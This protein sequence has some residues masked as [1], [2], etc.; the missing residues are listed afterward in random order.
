MSSSLNNIPQTAHPSLRDNGWSLKIIKSMTSRRQ[1]MSS[2]DYGWYHHA[3]IDKGTTSIRMPFS[4]HAFSSRVHE[5]T[6]DCQRLL[7]QTSSVFPQT[8]AVGHLSIN[9][10]RGYILRG[11]SFTYLCYSAIVSLYDSGI[12]RV[13]PVVTTAASQRPFRHHGISLDADAKNRFRPPFA[14]AHG[15]R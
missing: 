5:V 15:W 9:N 1:H 7:Q 6:C 8:I 13:R 11:V 4:G 10:R 2:C 12:Q 3:E 14:G